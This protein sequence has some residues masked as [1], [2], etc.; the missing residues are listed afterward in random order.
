M[1]R[2]QRVTRVPVAQRRSKRRSW[3]AKWSQEGYAPYWQA[4]TVPD[5]VK[6]AVDSGWFQ[7]G[8]ALL[9]IGCGSGENA[10]W[11]AEQ[12]F[13]VLGVDFSKPAIDRAKSEHVEAPGSLEFKV[14]DI[15]REAPPPARF[16]AL[17][18]RGCFHG[19]PRGFRS[20]YMRNI[21]S[22]CVPGTRM[23]LFAENRTT[24]LG[25][26]VRDI[27]KAF[28]PMFEISR[29]AKTHLAEVPGVAIWIVRR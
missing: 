24:T 15:C 22:C 17:L 3:E 27:E 11:L 16:N 10:A 7:P 20:S 13:E 12:G 29:T 25:Q 5:E 4:Q 6:D 9:D 8:A 2:L 14:M 26:R 21:V 23:L 19:I 1:R 18:D 28:L